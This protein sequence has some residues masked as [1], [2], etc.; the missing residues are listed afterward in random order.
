MKRFVVIALFLCGSLLSSTGHAAAPVRGHG[1][2]GIG[3]TYPESRPGAARFLFVQH[4][5][6]GSPAAQAGLMPQDLIVS[7]EGRPIGFADLQE[8]LRFF[9]D[10]RIGQTLHLAVARAGKVTKAVVVAA[11]VPPQYL[12]LVRPEPGA[13]KLR[14]APQ[15][16]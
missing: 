4:V 1:W 7:I 9:R 11:E 5:I 2:L 12:P 14:P 10:V 6:A 16:W 15:R 3:V 13:T 8:V